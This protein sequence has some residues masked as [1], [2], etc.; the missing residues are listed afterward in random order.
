MKIAYFR[1]VFFLFLLTYLSYNFQAF[2]W[3]QENIF[4]IYMKVRQPHLNLKCL[5]FAQSPLA[6]SLLSSSLLNFFN[7]KKSLLLHN[8]SLLSTISTHTFLLSCNL[9]HKNPNIDQDKLIL[10]TCI[11]SLFLFFYW[12]IETFFSSFSLPEL[13]YLPLWIVSVN[14]MQFFYLNLKTLILLYV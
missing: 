9:L 13:K 6:I 5:L 14:T 12:V 2:M 8:S 3:K 10:L 1:F 11:F 4:P 7:T